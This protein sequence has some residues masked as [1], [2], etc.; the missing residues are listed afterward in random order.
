VLARWGLRLIEAKIQVVLLSE[1]FGF[2]VA[3]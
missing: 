1:S 2:L 3:A